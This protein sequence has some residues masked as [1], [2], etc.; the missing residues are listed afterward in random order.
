MNECRRLPT[1]TAKES[2]PSPNAR[3]HPI[4]N[5][6]AMIVLVVAAMLGS[7][8]AVAATITGL[9]INGVLL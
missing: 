9:N 4:Q 7:N 2:S 6:L 3:R 8:S 1:G 5:A